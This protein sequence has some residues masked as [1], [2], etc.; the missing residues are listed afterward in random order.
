MTVESEAGKERGGGWMGVKIDIFEYVGIFPRL[1]V[2]FI[3]A[4]I[5]VHGV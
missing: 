5:G 4:L 3:E 2:F 1:F